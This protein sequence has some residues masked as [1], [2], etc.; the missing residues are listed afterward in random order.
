MESYRPI[1]SEEK[2][3]YGSMEYNYLFQDL[4]IEFQKALKENRYITARDLKKMLKRLFPNTKFSV[5]TRKYAGG[6]SV[7]IQYKDGV[8]LEKVEKVVDWDTKDFNGMYDISLSTRYKVLMPDMTIRK[9]EFDWYGYVSVRREYSKEA[10]E[11]AIEELGL[12]NYA[13]AENYYDGTGYVNTNDFR[14]SEKIYNYLRH[15]DI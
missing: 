14:V 7:D 9:I 1:F 5:R 6:S 11:Q 15:K 4:P 12:E 8:A 13:T 2:D 3:F 10:I